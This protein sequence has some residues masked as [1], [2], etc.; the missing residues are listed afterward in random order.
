[1]SKSVKGFT[2]LNETELQNINLI[3]E[4]VSSVFNRYGF[5]SIETPLVEDMN[6][7][8]KYIPDVDRPNN[9]IFS[10]KNSEEDIGLRYDLTAPLSRYVNENINSI[11]FPYRVC[12]NGYVFRDEKTK[13]GRLCQFLQYDAD[14]IGT[15]DE[16]SEIET[17]LIFMDI[18]KKL[19]FAE[20][21]Y[22]I[23]IGDRKIL[24]NI[25]SNFS[26]DKKLPIFRAVDKLEKIDWEG[27]E[28]LLGK[29]RMDESGDFTK[30]VGLSL[31]EIKFIIGKLYNC[32]PSDKTKRILSS[33]GKIN[34]KL[35]MFFRPELVRGLSYYTDFV[36]EC[37]VD[38]LKIGSVAG[39]GRYNGL[40]KD[41]KGNPVSA[42]G[43]SIG[44]SRL[45]H[46]MEKLN[47]FPSQNKYEDKILITI[48]DWDRIDDYYA[49]AYD[50]RSDGYKVEVYQGDSK[51]LGKQLDYA[52][53]NRF[54]FCIIQ[55][56]NE[57]N[58]NVVI[59]KDMK[60][61]T[62]KETPNVSWSLSCLFSAYR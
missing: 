46:A 19:G 18:M 44:V 59:L 4:S 12:R 17:V 22:S 31:K 37:S 35:R 41:K 23:K 39:G 54:R 49:I 51:K 57:M 42:V 1:M 15:E 28:Q 8:G 43:I 55:G 10:F 3:K 27:V 40:I 13:P 38:A 29:G 47:K 61:K 5:D 25:L 32:D 30:G 50:L 48:M 14:I 2:D 36:V 9:G 34:N 58:K 7:I 26:D 16:Y 33:I 60:E 62:Q 53:K 45:A 21:E 20:N 52:N 11:Q 24:D 56:E 6:K